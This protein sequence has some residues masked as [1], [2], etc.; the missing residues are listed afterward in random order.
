MLRMFHDCH[1]LCVLL[2]FVCV[3]HWCVRGVDELPMISCHLCVG[4][5]AV[6]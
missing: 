2:T 5:V 4:V 3:V 1:D 6:Y